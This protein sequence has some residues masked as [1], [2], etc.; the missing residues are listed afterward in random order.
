MYDAKYRVSCR[1][2]VQP[3]FN[4]IRHILNL[5]QVLAMRETKLRLVSF[6]GD[7]TLYSDGACFSDRKLARF[8]TLLL[9][10]GVHASLV[11]AAGYG[12]D[13]SRYAARL[14]GLLEYFAHL[15][16]PAE[17][18]ERFWVRAA[19]RTSSPPP[20]HR[21]PSSA[22]PC[23]EERVVQASAGPHPARRDLRRCSAASATTSSAA[24]PCLARTGACG[25]S[26]SRASSSGCSA[27]CGSPTTARCRRCSTWRRRRCR[28]RC[29][30]CSCATR[31]SASRAP[32]ASCPAARRASSSS[33]RGTAPPR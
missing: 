27:A 17:V 31:S 2:F 25:T 33:R 8:I 29:A 6:D 14:S 1:R 16:L 30:R 10:N 28:R 24:P 23:W 19:A 11:T 12:H 13:C 26:C 5:A 18:V 7:C 32:S 15:Q 22:T 9:K 4:E 20:L 21:H 3:S